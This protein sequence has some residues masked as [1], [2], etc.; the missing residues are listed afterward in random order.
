MGTQEYEN[1]STMLY[2]LPVAIIN[3]TED[4]LTVI[5]KT[6]W[7]YAKGGAWTE[8][9]GH[10]LTLTLGGSGTSGM[11]RIRASPIHTFSIVVEYHIYE[12]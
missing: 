9:A 3:D 6:S 7:Y 11:L 1:C 4:I 5:E 8:D 12:F 10:K 2:T